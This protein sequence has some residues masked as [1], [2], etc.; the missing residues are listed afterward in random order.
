MDRYSKI[1]LTIIAIALSTLVL[2]NAGALPSAKL[3]SFNTPALA[4]PAEPQK[5]QLCNWD[6][7]IAEWDC[8]LVQGRRLSVKAN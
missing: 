3:L 6:N 7:T 1:V 2:Q 8:A 4:D 5:V